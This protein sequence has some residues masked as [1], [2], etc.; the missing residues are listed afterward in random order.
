MKKKRIIFQNCHYV[1]QNQYSPFSYKS[2]PIN[3]F[4]IFYE[5]QGL[6][7]D[8]HRP[9]K[10]QKRP[11]EGLLWTKS[12]WKRRLD[13]KQNQRFQNDIPEDEREMVAINN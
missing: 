3:F 8:L 12:K 1:S 6:T 11:I 2:L 9:S 10:G 5:K 7:Y 4:L 13:A